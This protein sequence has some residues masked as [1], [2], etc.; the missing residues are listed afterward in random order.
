MTCIVNVHYPLTHVCSCFLFLPVPFVLSCV[1]TCQASVGTQQTWSVGIKHS[2]KTSSLQRSPRPFWSSCGKLY[3][4]WHSSYWRLLPS[5]PLASLSTSLQERK[6]NVRAG[7][8]VW[9]VVSEGVGNT[10]LFLTPKGRFHHCCVK[11]CVKAM[12]YFFSCL[13]GQ[14]CYAIISNMNK[15]K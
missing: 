1:S 5:S 6:V 3:R 12:S 13:V 10:G 2:A 7:R 15:P 14:R 8:E 4:M 9:E 11:H